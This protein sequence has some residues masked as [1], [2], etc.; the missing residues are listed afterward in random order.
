LVVA[1]GIDNIGTSI[2][3]GRED[4][5]AHGSVGREPLLIHPLQHFHVDIHIVIDNDTLLALEVP[6]QSPGILGNVAF[7]GDWHG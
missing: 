4:G 2:P 5:I 1:D 6:V 7:P 3:C